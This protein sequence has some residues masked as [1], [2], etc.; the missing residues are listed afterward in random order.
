MKRVL[1]KIGA[2][3]MMVCFLAM[4]AAA[5]DNDLAALLA[6]LKG[7]QPVTKAEL[8]KILTELSQYVQRDGELELEETVTFE[9]LMRLQR[10]S[11]Q[12]RSQT[13]EIERRAS[14]LSAEQKELGYQLTRIGYGAQGIIKTKK[15]EL[16]GDG[17]SAALDFDGQS[18]YYD[19]VQPE[20][21]SNGL[22][23]NGG[24]LLTL[25]GRPAAET[26]LSGDVVVNRIW[27]GASS[28][29][30]RSITLAMEGEDRLT[31]GRFQKSWSPYSIYFPISE[32]EYE[33][34]LFSKVRESRLS[35]QG[36]SGPNRI[37][38]GIDYQKAAEDYAVNLLGAKIRTVEGS[39]PFYRYL[40]GAKGQ[41]KLLANL[42]LNL[43]ALTLS[44]LART[45]VNEK[46]G[47]Q[48]N[49]V[50]L[51][52][53]WRH[54]ALSVASE[55][56]RSSYNEAFLKE[57][58]SLPGSAKRLQVS[59][60][61]GALEL[62]AAYSYV[63]PHF[64]SFT[65]QS[66]DLKLQADGNFGSGELL[67]AEN[68]PV[69]Q[70][71]LRFLPYGY[72]T[73]NRKWTELRVALRNRKLDTQLLYQAGGEIA[74]ATLDGLIVGTTQNLKAFTR[75]KYGLRLPLQVAGLPLDFVCGWRQDQ[76][77]WGDDPYSQS[78]EVTNCFEDTIDA[79]VKLNWGAVNCL[80]GIKGIARR[81]QYLGADVDT[82]YSVKSIGVEY[83]LSRQASISLYR[84]FYDYGDAE[85]AANSYAGP[86][87]GFEFAVS[88]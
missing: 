23:M 39:Y 1:L 43:E 51:G 48:N 64:V 88:Y 26:L 31:V 79:G 28:M 40:W 22:K 56:A 29:E 19:P 59:G 20:I 2:L 7:D 32:G 72:A 63:D 9:D 4:G 35:D 52:L 54:G 41:L 46:Y 58:P 78:A 5:A 21:I 87:A 37:L 66:R 24:L 34:Q 76:V 57:I 15:Y 68:V 61:K 12:I 49:V 62:S 80:A 85:D 83:L 55:M 86:V 36:I 50:N 45:P 25:Y 13:G 10:L 77:R 8:E 14:D 30:L 11:G 75:L 42:D 3:L 38:E 65:A 74:D 71:G 60:Q 18:L 47:E 84:N 73:P 16:T 53:A 67:T 6:E 33:S 70:G 44:D 81:G 17:V 69:S 27:G 82:R